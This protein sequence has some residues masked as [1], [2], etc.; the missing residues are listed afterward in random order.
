MKLAKLKNK[1]NI[2]DITIYSLIVLFTFS[3]FNL[4]NIIF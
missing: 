2:T 4:I 3:I 1:F